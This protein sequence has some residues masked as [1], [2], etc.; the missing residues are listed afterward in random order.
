M[1]GD[2]SRGGKTKPGFHHRGTEDTEKWKKFLAA[3][4]RAGSARI[5]RNEERNVE[6]MC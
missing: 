3:E 6:S 2:D 1:G 4:R 5:E